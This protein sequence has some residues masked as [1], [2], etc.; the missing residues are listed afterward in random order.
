MQCHD[1]LCVLLRAALV[2]YAG[3]ELVWSLERSVAVPLRRVRQRFDP[4]D[5]RED[6]NCPGKTPATQMM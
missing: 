5:R 6:Q 3:E 2:T 4:V 1:H